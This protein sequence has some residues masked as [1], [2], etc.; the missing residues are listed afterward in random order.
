MKELARETG[1]LA[2]FPKVAAELSG[3]Y[4]TIAAELTNQY[5]IA[6]TP[7]AATR[8]RALRQVSIRVS[9][10]P[11]LLTRTRINYVSSGPSLKMAS[12]R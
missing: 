9:S 11:A 8:N 7:R 4:E 2:Y 3:V 10:Q 5:S 1:A 12:L 6:Y